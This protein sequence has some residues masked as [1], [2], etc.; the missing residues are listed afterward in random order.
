M[1]GD[2]REAQRPGEFCLDELFRPQQAMVG[3]W[4]NHVGPSPQLLEDNV[5]QLKGQPLDDETGFGRAR[6]VRLE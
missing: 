3:A 1:L 5:Q 4:G 2:V 6:R